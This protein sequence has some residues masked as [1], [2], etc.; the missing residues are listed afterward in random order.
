MLGLATPGGRVTTTGVGG[1]SLGGGYGWLSPTYG[2][3]CDDLVSVDLVTASGD[4]MRVS[5]ETNPELMWAMR[6]AGANFGVVT[7]VELRV[8]PVQP[9]VMA[10]VLVVPNDDHAG[11]VLRAYRDDLEPAP[12]DLVT[13]I[14]TVLAPPAD[15]VPP[16]LVDAPVVG[17][18]V[19]WFGDPG[20]AEQMVA[21]LRAIT[22]GGVD[23]IQPMPYTAFQGM[24]DDFAPPGWLN[25]H[26]G[27]HISS[28]PD[29]VL[30]NY[31][32]VG[33]SIGSPMTRSPA[34]RTRPTRTA[35]W[36]G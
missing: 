5:D 26:R 3:T 35:R 21:P 8:H 24:L 29:G 22:E 11:E 30:D 9:L 31:L 15:F 27:Q 4:L 23:L 16:E 19:A 33:Q 18:I 32:A 6:G 14:A 25:Y 1:F 28:L 17:I 10:G 7:N 12:E 36:P 2:L 20:E 13:A 34:G